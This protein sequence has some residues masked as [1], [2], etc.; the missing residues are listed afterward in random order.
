MSLVWL[1][2]S[3]AAVAVCLCWR[4]EVFSVGLPEQHSVPH[5]LSITAQ[6]RKQE[7]NQYRSTSNS[8]KPPLWLQAFSSEGRVH[9]ALVNDYPAEDGLWTAPFLS[10]CF[11][12][13]FPEHCT[14][15]ILAHGRDPPHGLITSA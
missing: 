14:H 6:S 13:S 11:F 7:P 10:A 15:A 8:V 1:L 2:P 4:T 9:C 3:V 5:Q 12:F